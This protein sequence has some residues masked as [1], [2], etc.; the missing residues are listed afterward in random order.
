MVQ[1]F[2]SWGRYP[3]VSQNFYKPIWL[4]SDLA[5]YGSD[6]L[7]AYGQG[8]SYGDVALNGDNSIIVTTSLNRF[9]SFN[10]ETGLLR[11]EA[12]VTLADILRFAVPRGWFLPVTPGTKFVSV[13]GAIANDVHG[14]NHHKAGCF[15]NYVPRFSLLRSDGK[16][17]CSE[18][19][20]SD[21][22][23]ATIGGIG[24]TGLILDA[25]IQ[26]KKIESSYIDMEGIQFSGLEEYHALSNESDKDYDY[27]VAW[28]DCI[29]SGDKFARGVYMR[30]NHCSDPKYGKKTHRDPFLN[31]PF[32]FPEWCVN[33]YSMKLIN[34]LYYHKQIHKKVKAIQHYEPFFYPLDMVNNWNRGYGKR[35]LLQFQCVIPSDAAE[36][37]LKE[38]LYKIVDNGSASFLSVIK[39]FGD[40]KSPGMLSFPRKGTTLC[41]DFPFRGD[42][43]FKLFKTLEDMTVEAG[44]ALYPAKDACMAGESFKKFYPRWKE[45]SKFIDPRFSSSF[46]R[47]VIGENHA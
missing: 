2:Q 47:R 35:G 29:T 4:P 6:L 43:S 15:G 38:M 7:L 37:V 16:K 9:I 5:T 20:N 45:F 8:R 40:M 13:G 39:D 33:R 36:G 44:G 21:L 11:C 24:L 42:S 12:G 10:N 18:T 28:I 23:A 1:N 25:D 22:Y 26:L 32:I 30:G 41:M 46:W 19:E 27:T 17:E 31:V 14:K 3:Q 34:T